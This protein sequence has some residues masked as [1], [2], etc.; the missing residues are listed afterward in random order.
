MAA[1]EKIVGKPITVPEHNDVTGAIGVAI[2]AMRER[3][4]ENSR[5]K[6]FDLAQVQYEIS[7]FECKGCPNQCEIKKVSIEGEKPLFYGS[8]CDKYDLDTKKTVNASMPDL[9]AE[10]EAWMAGEPEGL[11]SRR[12][13]RKNRYP[14]DHVFQ[15]AAAFFPNFFY[16]P[17]V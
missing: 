3:T 1:F 15:G 17:G 10:R 8:R 7:S 4:W 5:F 2:L 6:G 11:E 13:T 14:Q 9:F 16:Q 12:E